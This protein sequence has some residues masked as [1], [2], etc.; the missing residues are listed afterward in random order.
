MDSNSLKQHLMT[1]PDPDN[2]EVVDAARN[3][4][5]C[6]EIL[7]E[8]QQF[9]AQLQAALAVPSRPNLAQ[10]IMARQKADAHGPELPWM[11]ATAAAVTLTIGV[12]AMQLIP[13]EEHGHHGHGDVW[14][15]LTEHWSHDGAEV[16]ASSQTM[17]SQPEE[18]ERLLA[19]LG[20]DADPRLIAQVSLGKVCPTPDGDGAHLVLNTAEG[21]I[22]LIIMPSTESPPLPSSQ[23]MSDG[24]EAWL[25][26]LEQ[27][28]MAVIA[29]PDQD[30]FELARQLGEQVSVSDTLS[31]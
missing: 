15:H 5:D 4:E 2:P 18:I 7:R 16:L 9:E 17:N 24:K 20:V 8:S 25:V 30:A 14:V 26:G 23:T 19:G 1:D 3:S 29:D 31:L 6:A 13:A 21:P 28:S 27:G 12:V 10:D 22:T 11:L